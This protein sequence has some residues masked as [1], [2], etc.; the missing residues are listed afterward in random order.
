MHKLIIAGF[1]ALMALNAGY[2]QAEPDHHQKIEFQDVELSD[3]QL[4]ELEAMYE[5]VINQRKGIIEKYQSFGVLTEADA[6]LMSKQLDQYMEKLRSDNFIPK[7]HGP[8]KHKKEV[9]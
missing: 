2:V 4:N 1:I 7:W 5:D 9:E 8:K 3:Q 6:T